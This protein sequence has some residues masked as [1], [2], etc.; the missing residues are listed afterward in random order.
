M[1]KRFDRLLLRVD[2]LPAAAKYWHDTH[3]ATILRQDRNSISL[4]LADGGEVVLHSDPN[5]PAEQLFILVD[6]VRAMHDLRADL[7]LDFRSPP[8][9]GSR[10]Y[11]ATIRDPFG[12]VLNISDRSLEEGTASD[13]TSGA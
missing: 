1:F 12:I 2:S 11:F 4:Q 9:R 10:G 5:L 8:T 13:S 7:L 6:D 3:G